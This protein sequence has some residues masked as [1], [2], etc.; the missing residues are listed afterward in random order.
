MDLVP[1]IIEP[2]QVSIWLTTGSSLDAFVY[3]NKYR[4]SGFVLGRTR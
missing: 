3:R 2:F 4:S 1:A